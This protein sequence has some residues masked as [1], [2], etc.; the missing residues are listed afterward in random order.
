[1]THFATNYSR[2]EVTLS[3]ALMTYWINFA[4]FGDP[5][6]WPENSDSLQRSDRFDSESKESSNSKIGYESVVW[7]TY[8]P[9]QRKYVTLGLKPKVRDH[10]HSH[11]LSF[12]LNLI[13]RLH[14]PGEEQ[15]YLRHHLLTDHEDLSTYDGVV[16]QIAYKFL[17]P[18]PT[19]SQNIVISATTELVHHMSSTIIT[20]EV[21]ELT[22]TSITDINHPTAFPAKNINNTTTTSVILQNENYS[23]ALTITIGIGCSLLILNMLIFAG[24]YY[25][26]DKNRNIA[27]N[28]SNQ[29]SNKNEDSVSINFF[30]LFS[31]T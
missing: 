8:D 10:Y 18:L 22:T 27:Q 13:P 21:V 6:V 4:K 5:N 16:R 20:T 9:I 19:V 11:R 17:A 25:Q 29:K 3:E 7:P 15:V 23:T 26:L 14:N 12:W 30:Y 28:N 2:A 31:N 1:M 24:V